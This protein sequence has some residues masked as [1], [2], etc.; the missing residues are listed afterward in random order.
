M[1][2]LQRSVGGPGSLGVPQAIEVVLFEPEVMADLMQQ[3]YPDLLGHRFVI[4]VPAARDKGDP[5]PKQMDLG[6]QHGIQVDGPFGKHEPCMQAAEYLDRFVLF[7]RGH[8]EIA[9]DRAIRLVH[10]MQRDLIQHS[11]DV[12]GQLG[13]LSFH[14]RIE[15]FRERL[16]DRP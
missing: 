11:A 12:F 16:G 1:L 5:A 4:G 6:G 9:Q 3:C 2:S 10:D 7:L 14:Q 13:E 8:T 15:A